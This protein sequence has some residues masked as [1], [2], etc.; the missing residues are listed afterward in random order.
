MRSRNQAVRL[1][2]ERAELVRQ[3][4]DQRVRAGLQ[5]ARLLQQQGHTLCENGNSVQGMHWLARS[6]EKVAETR[7]AGLDDDL[8]QQADDFED[9]VR[10]DLALCAHNVHHL[11]AV[12]PHK[13][14]VRAVAFSADGRLALTGGAVRGV[15]VWDAT[16]GEAAGKPL[17]NPGQV[18]AIAVNDTVVLTAGSRRG[19]GEAYL[20]DLATRKRIGP[21]LKGPYPFLAAALSPDGKTILT[22][23]ADGKAQLWDAASGQPR[24]DAVV[25][26]QPVLAVAFSPDGSRFATACG[27]FYTGFARCWDSATQKPTG[28]VLHR[29][30]ITAVAFLPDGKMILTTS[31]DE[32]ARLWDAASGAELKMLRHPG[33]GRAAVPSPDGTRVLLAGDDQTA[34]LWDLK[35]GTPVGSPVFHSGRVVAAAISPDGKLMLTGSEDHT[36]RL[37]R[38]ATGLEFGKPLHVQGGAFSAEYSRDGKTLAVS[39]SSG[40]VYLWDAATGKLRRSWRSNPSPGISFPIALSPKGDRLVAGADVPGRVSRQWDLATGKEGPVLKSGPLKSVAWSPDGKTI[41]TGSFSFYGKW[42]EVAHEARRWNAAS[43]RFLAPALKHGGDVWAVSFTRDGKTILTG[44]GDKT[45][46]LW[47]AGTGQPIGKPMLHPAEVWAAIFSPDEKF[48]LTAGRDRLVRVW[49]AAERRPTGKALAHPAEVRTLAISPDGKLVLTGSRDGFSRLWNLTTRSPL[50]PPLPQHAIVEKVVFAPNGRKFL[51]MGRTPIVRQWLV[52]PAV[53]GD[54]GQVRAWVET[55]T[56]LHLDDNDA[57]VVL[58]PE[59]WRQLLPGK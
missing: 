29:G 5:A 48:I 4:K 34:R 6:L 1:A 30:E 17:P 50:G 10:L 28:P 57:V 58:D 7:A 41:V 54:A 19:R 16:T 9:A 15:F 27:R 23:S 52:P 55:V 47:D 31:M 18:R 8:L 24:G 53:T 21:V 42:P 13:G 51:T 56:G 59:Q 32:T 2:D 35:A 40:F 26:P 25:H 37:C 49:D 44:S 36:A 12:L 14:A 22:G 11:L 39:D 33:V 46:R 3:E 20:W 45:A 43:G 38:I